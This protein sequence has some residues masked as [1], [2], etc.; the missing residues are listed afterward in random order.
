MS[1]RRVGLASD[2]GESQGEDTQD[3]ANGSVVNSSLWM[4]GARLRLKLG[5]GF[6]RRS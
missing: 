3:Y 1:A 4:F 6:D 5:L 2:L